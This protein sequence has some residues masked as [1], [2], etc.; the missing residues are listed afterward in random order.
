MEEEEENFDFIQKFNYSN[1]FWDNTDILYQH[2]RLRMEE[3]SHVSN[4]FNQI[5]S[6]LNEFATSLKHNINTIQISKE[7]FVTTRNIAIGKVLD[8]IKKIINNLIN[9]STKLIDISQ[10]INDKVEAYQTRKDFEKLC[11]ENFVKFQDN[12]KKLNLRQEIYNDAV[13]SVLETFL[14]Y[15]YKE[16]KTTFDLKPK[17]DFLYKKKQEY[18]NEVKKCEEKRTEFIGLQRNMLEN[19]EEFDRE[20]T[21]E[22]KHNL[23]EGMKFYN[24]FLEK[25]KIDEEVINSIEKINADKDIQNFSEKNRD[26]M[27]SPSKISFIEYNQD[28]EIYYNFEGIKNKLKNKTENEQKEFKR[29]ISFEVNKFLEQALINIDDN[30]EI[31]N[32][33]SLIANEILNGKL[34]EEDYQFII[35]EFQNKYTDFME[36]KR[37]TIGDRDYLK[38]GG[39]WDDRFDSMHAFLNIFNKKRMFNKK[40][41]KDNYNYYVKIMEKILELNDGDELDYVLCDLV[42][43][44]AAT[45]YRTEEK[46]GKEVKIYVS[47]AIK[48]NKIFQK[49]EFWVGMVK[50]QINEEII[51]EDMKIKEIKRKNSFF[52]TFNKNLTSLNINFNLNFKLNIPLLGKKKEDNKVDNVDKYNKIIMAKLMSVCYNLVQSVTSDDTLNKALY[53]IFRF[54]KL[55]KENRKTIIDM[56]N[57]Q[58]AAEGFDFLKIDEDLL[59]NNDF[60]NFRNKENKNKDENNENKE[61]ENQEN[62]ENKEKELLEEMYGDGDNVLNINEI[63]NENKIEN[64][65]EKEE[66]KKEEKIKINKEIKENQEVKEKEEINENKEIKENEEIKENDIKTD[67]IEKNN[68]IKKDS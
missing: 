46:D 18:K 54:Y 31:I 14:Y 43:I 64:I 48:N 40:L 53:N 45:F 44:L 37:T 63:K 33:Y 50:N 35:N 6:S 30:N 4:L 23:N 26:I 66:I 16:T 60:H 1:A 10:M 49:Y 56:L 42:I 67:T 68:E 28:M 59:L 39:G 21:E 32:R 55:S 27:S 12:L 34:K 57:F 13:Q 29:E 47:E 11:K 7:E 3:Y 5:S 2:S 38:V 65:K 51:K 52:N 19:E 17:L 41:E 9:F 61:K 24:E 22:L 8:F 20:C 25:C 58:I 15:K 62:I 36:W